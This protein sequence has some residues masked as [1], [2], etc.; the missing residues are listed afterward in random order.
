M[1]FYRAE[2]GGKTY[3]EGDG[4]DI[5]GDVIS[6]ESTSTSQ[7]GGIKIDDDTIGINS[8]NQIYTK[9][10]QTITLSDNTS[11]ITVGSTDIITA[12][13]NGG[14]TLSVSSSDST[15]A[16]A[17]V[18]NSEV[19]ITGVGAGNCT[20]TVNASASGN[21][22]STSAVISVTIEAIH[23]YGA[24]W[25]GSS[26]P[27][28]TRTDDAALFTDPNPY[29]SG[30]SGSPSSPFDNIMPWSGMRIVEDADAGTL[31][32]IPKFWYKWTKNGDVMKLQ[33]ADGPQTGFYVSPAHADRDDGVGERDYAYVSRYNL[34]CNYKSITNSTPKSDIQ[35]SVARTNSHNLG[36][37][38]WQYDFA[39]YWTIAMLYLVEYAH[40]NSQT[41]IGCGG[42]TYYSGSLVN[43]GYTDS[44]PYH[45]GTMKPYKDSTN[46]NR[47]GPSTQYRHIEGLWDNLYDTIDGIYFGSYD[48]S[49]S[50]EP[51]RVYCIKNPSQF[52]DN[53]NGTYVCN[54]CYTLSGSIITGWNMSRSNLTGF[55]Y[56]LYPG[57][58]I[59]SSDNYDIYVCDTHAFSESSSVRPNRGTSLKAGGSYI[60]NTGSCGLFNLLWNEDYT[61]TGT[62]AGARLM[63]L[64]PTRLSP[65]SP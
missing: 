9:L 40:W 6:L 17:S 62:Y 46:V 16:T 25:D 5:T 58:A 7:F 34:D 20:I 22:G 19:I 64:P 32:E 29:Y 49:S 21:Y 3:T 50:S 23:V 55:E 18:S 65:P 48:A 33:I 59:Y 4:I 45:T 31:V 24:E 30:M 37:N 15:V 8:N 51:Q 44:M 47:W 38:I 26:D 28:W 14:G 12:T 13:T 41:K 52:S 36:L 11:S 56:V 42:G 61:S 43:N 63:V 35:K 54:R 2:L 57:T 27:S 1:P 39:M 10:K 53:S 60:N